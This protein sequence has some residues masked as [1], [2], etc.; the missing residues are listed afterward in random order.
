MLD[1]Y[2]EYFW[3]PNLV[4]QPQRGEVKHGRGALRNNTCEIRSVSLARRYVPY[5]VYGHVTST[6]PL[7]LLT[8]PAYAYVDVGKKPKI[9]CIFS[10]ILHLLT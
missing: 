8:Y 7:M 5:T 6:K 1:L 9:N 2:G 4:I 10:L 3:A